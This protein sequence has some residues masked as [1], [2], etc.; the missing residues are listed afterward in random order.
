MVLSN[1]NTQDVSSAFV[2]YTAGDCHSGTTYW[3]MTNQWSII[4]ERFNAYHSGC[5][6]VGYPLCSIMTINRVLMGV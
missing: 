3:F 5:V 4:K 2:P 6:V 1:I